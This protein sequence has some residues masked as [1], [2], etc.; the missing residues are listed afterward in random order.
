M[1]DVSSV[2]F[3]LFFS[4]LTSHT[5][6]SLRNVCAYLAPEAVIFQAEKE[7]KVVQSVAQAVSPLRRVRLFCH[8]NLARRL[9]RQNL[10]ILK[11]HSVLCVCG[12]GRGGRQGEGGG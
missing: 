3:R 4:R 9:V 10:K 7:L 1:Q 11:P 2:S 5:L 6:R 8:V 12:V